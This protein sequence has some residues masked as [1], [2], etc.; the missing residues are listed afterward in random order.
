VYYST[1][2]TRR[3]CPHVSGLFCLLQ[4]DRAAGP[5]F[6]HPALTPVPVHIPPHQVVGQG[7]PVE[8]ADFR[9]RGHE[10]DAVAGRLVPVARG[11]AQID[12]AVVHVHGH[13]TR[14]EAP[15][16]RHGRGQVG[17]ERYR[18]DGGGRGRGCGGICGGGRGC[19]G[20]GPGA[21]GR[22][23]NVQRARD[24][25]Q[26]H[27]ER[28]EGDRGEEDQGQDHARDVG[29]VV[30]ETMHDYSTIFSPSASSRPGRST[31]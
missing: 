6:G 26:I 3:F 21:I 1:S 19:D 31:A 25:G 7:G 4:H 24:L 10:C 5:A 2:S 17:R 29:M 27:G 18:Q 11:F 23:A 20:R 30:G 28:G 13:I 12:R 9:A 8:D 15:L 14:L 22:G 16:A